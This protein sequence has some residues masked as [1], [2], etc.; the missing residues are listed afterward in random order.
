MKKLSIS[1]LQLEGEE[2]FKP[3]SKK[4]SGIRSPTLPLKCTA[5]ANCIFLHCIRRGVSAVSLRIGLS[6]YPC[7]FPVS[8]LVAFFFVCQ[9]SKLL[10]HSRFKPRQHLSF[11]FTSVRCRLLQ[12]CLLCNEFSQ[13][14]CRCDDPCQGWVAE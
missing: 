4:W 9:N 5:K 3:F 6:H 13:A 2:D 10:P 7:S 8:C 12:V 14:H 1:W 11:S